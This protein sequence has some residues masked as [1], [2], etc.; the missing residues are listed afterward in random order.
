MPAFVNGKRRPYRKVAPTI[1]KARPVAAALARLG[2]VRLWIPRR[3]RVVVQDPPALAG[4][5]VVIYAID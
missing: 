4:V 5:F 3:G 2:V 1:W